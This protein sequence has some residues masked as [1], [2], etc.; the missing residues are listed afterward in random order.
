MLKLGGEEAGFTVYSG[1]LSLGACLGYL[2]TALDWTSIGL[3]QSLGLSSGKLLFT[4]FFQ[5]FTRT[6]LDKTVQCTGTV[7]TV[8]V[9][10]YMGENFDKCAGI[11]VVSV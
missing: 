7:N 5:D 2:L 9:L 3:T 8:P 10:V 1:M 4:S 6:F 11:I